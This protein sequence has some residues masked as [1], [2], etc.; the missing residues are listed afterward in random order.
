MNHIGKLFSNCIELQ[1]VEIY[2]NHLESTGFITLA[3]ILCQISSLKLINFQGK[4]NDSSSADDLVF[5]II[6]NPC[7]EEVIFGNSN[8]VKFTAQRYQ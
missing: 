6:Y 2:A 5:V 8:F 1:K 4:N 7:L 3:K